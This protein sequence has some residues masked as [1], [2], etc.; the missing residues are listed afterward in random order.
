[1]SLNVHVFLRRHDLPTVVSW[2]D[3]IAANDFPMELGRTFNPFVDSGFVPCSFRG[4]QTGFEYYLSDRNSVGE[5][6]PDLQADIEDFDAAVS[7]RW[8][9]DLNECATAVMSA[10]ALTILVKGLMYYPND[11]IRISFS[12]AA[13][14]GRKTLA[15]IDSVQSAA[16]DNLT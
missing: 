6:Y 2:Q 14:Y 11:Q 1:V 10:A 7:L 16:S 13:E 8:G 3:A 4:T 9:G 15:E 12:E 5:S